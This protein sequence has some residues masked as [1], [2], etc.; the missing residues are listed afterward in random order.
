MRDQLCQWHEQDPVDD[1]EALRDQRIAY[2]QGGKNNPFILDCSLVKRAY[3]SELPACTTAST[4]INSAQQK[5]HVYA[6]I[7]EI[8]IEDKQD[9]QWQ[10]RII[11][12]EGQCLFS[13][14]LQSNSYTDILALPTG[15][16]I[17]YAISGSTLLVSKFYLP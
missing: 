1:F 9:R 10:L 5:I 13:T 12:I 16:Y 4:E 7:G 3:C 8:S 11:N 17:A 6:P 15:F 2:Y 14:L